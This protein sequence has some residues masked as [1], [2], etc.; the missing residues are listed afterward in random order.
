M[1]EQQRVALHRRAFEVP[2][3]SVEEVLA[4]EHDAE[5]VVA[6]HVHELG[7]AAPA[8]DLSFGQPGRPHQLGVGGGVL[9][10][11]PFDHPHGDSRFS[12]AIR[13]V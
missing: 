12:F 8:V 7:R 11:E 5:L 1:V 3:L 6:R 13:L 10:F 4:L 9:S 2:P